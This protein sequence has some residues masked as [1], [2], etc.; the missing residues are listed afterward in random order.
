[1]FLKVRL[2]AATNPHAPFNIY[3]AVAQAAH[4]KKVH[5]S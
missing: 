2:H 3:I 1:M 5:I 4:D